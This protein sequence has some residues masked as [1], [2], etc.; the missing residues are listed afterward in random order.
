MAGL[1]KKYAQMGFKRGWKAYKAT[2]G[3]TSMAKRTKRT[4][5][6]KI[7][8]SEPKRAKRSSMGGGIMRRL[9][10]IN[11]KPQLMSAGY[12]V[13]RGSINAYNPLNRFFGKFGKYSDELAMYALAQGVKAVFPKAK[14]I[15]NKAQDIEAF[16][17][18]FQAG[19]D[20]N[21]I[22]NIMGSMGGNTTAAS[23]SDGVNV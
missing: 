3:A 22:A 6:T 15:A 18:G 16:L 5:T 4:K 2:K 19:G 23:N 9:T 13:V 8:Y 17:M 11:W 14:P 21:L 12:G 1:P 20:S 10:N 7:S